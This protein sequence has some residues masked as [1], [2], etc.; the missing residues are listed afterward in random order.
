[1][2]DQS[3]LE[4]FKQVHL[5]L[6]EYPYIYMYVYIHVMLDWVYSFI[7]DGEKF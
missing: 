5:K 2:F 3:F 4:W 6:P 7:L 1:M